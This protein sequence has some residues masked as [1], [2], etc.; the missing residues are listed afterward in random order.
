MPSK[1]SSQVIDVFS[2]ASDDA[3]GG[4]FDDNEENEEFREVQHQHTNT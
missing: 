2:E 1:L 4:F 3:F